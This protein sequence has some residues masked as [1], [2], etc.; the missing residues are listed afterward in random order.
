MTRVVNCDKCHIQVVRKKAIMRYPIFM[1]TFY[2]F[3][4]KCGKEY[5]AIEKAIDKEANEIKKQAIKEF[6]NIKT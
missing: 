2:Y 5:D 3:C 1:G 6:L 4:L